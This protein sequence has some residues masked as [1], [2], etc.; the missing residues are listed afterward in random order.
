MQKYIHCT[1]YLFLILYNIYDDNTHDEPLFSS[2]EFVICPLIYVE[3]Y[4]TNSNN[5][6]LLDTIEFYYSHL[7]I[8]YVFLNQESIGDNGLLFCKFQLKYALIIFMY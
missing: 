4:M 8:Q 6:F 3:V 2:L 1:F 7:T 5:K